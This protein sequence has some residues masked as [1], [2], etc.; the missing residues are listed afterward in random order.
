MCVDIVIVCLHILQDTAADIEAHRAR[1]EEMCD[2]CKELIAR[3]IQ[4]GEELQGKLNNVQQ[5]WDAILVSHDSKVAL[6]L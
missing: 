5:R 1:Y 2:K 4:D 6:T 3:G